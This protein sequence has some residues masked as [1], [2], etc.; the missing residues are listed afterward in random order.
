MSKI[1]SKVFPETE[2]YNDLQWDNE[3]L[4]SI[5]HPEDADFI[6][7]MIKLNEFVGLIV[8]IFGLIIL[9]GR[10]FYKIKKYV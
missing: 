1:K 4:W 7:E 10:I 5:T 9:D 2:K 3:G 8:I 6:S